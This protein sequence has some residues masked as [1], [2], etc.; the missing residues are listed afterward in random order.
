MHSLRTAV[1]SRTAT[2]G[3]RSVGRLLVRI[4]VLPFGGVTAAA[5]SIAL[6]AVS[7]D[8]PSDREIC[9]VI[10][11]QPFGALE[12]TATSRERRRRTRGNPE[13]PDRH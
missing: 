7:M 13:W 11:D 4:G 2:S 9:R 8:F 6:T 10:E 3:A 5:A 12:R 1:G